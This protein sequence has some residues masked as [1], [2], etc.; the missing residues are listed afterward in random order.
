MK[1]SEK[2]KRLRFKKCGAQVVLEIDLGGIDV[3]EDYDDVVK[4]F[5]KI[6]EKMPNNSVDCLIDLTKARCNELLY[7]KIKDI[8]RNG[9]HH[10][11]R[12]VMIADNKSKAMLE[13]VALSFNT[14]NTTHIFTDINAARNYL[15]N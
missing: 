12:S 3:Y 8:Y 11:N 6:V 5:V 13:P 2:M 7:A 15:S 9:Q 1:L 14:N 4:Y 10:L